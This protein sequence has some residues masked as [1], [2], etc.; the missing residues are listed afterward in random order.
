MSADGTGSAQRY[1]SWQQVLGVGL[2][3]ACSLLSSHLSAQT[4]LSTIRGVVTDTSGGVLPG[5]DIV[6]IDVSTNLSRSTVSDAA[7]NFEISHL[8]P[9]TYRLEAHFPGFKGFIADN[10]ILESSQARRIDI[11]LAV[12]EL[13]SEV[14]VNP[15]A[16]VIETEDARLSAVLRNEQYQDTPFVSRSRF[17]P[18]MLLTLPGVQPPKAGHNLSLA[19]MT[20]QITQGMDGVVN[21]G[22]VNQIQNMDDV[23]ETK[24]VT[25]N[26]TA[27]VARAGSFNLVSKR[28]SNEFHGQVYYYNVDSSLNSRPFFATTKPTLD[29]HTY[30]ASASGP[31]KTGRTFFYT[32][33]NGIRDPSKNSIQSTVPTVVMRNG[34]F[35]ELLDE[36]N[37]IVIRDPLADTPFPGNVI[38]AARLNSVAREVQ[39]MI[40]PA[41]NL[42][43]FTANLDWQ[44]PYAA[45]Y[46]RVDYLTARIDHKV[47][48]NNELY[49]RLSQRFTPYVLSGSYPAL[50]W[51]RRRYAFQMAIND[52]HVF[53]PSLIHSFRFGWYRNR[54]TDGEAID[55]FTPLRGDRVVTDLGIQGVNRRGLSGA[56]FP[57][58]NITGHGAIS[59]NPSGTSTEDDIS[60]SDNVT[61]SMGRHVV[62][63][64]ADLR[65][66][67][68]A[69]ETVPGLNYGSFSFDGTWSG[70]PYA[71][72]LLGLP[73]TSERLD[74]LGL[75]KRSGYE[76][77]AYVMDSF[78]VS[79]RLTLDYGL[80]WDYF[81][82]G[83]YEDGLQFNWN[84]VTGD[85]IVPSAAMDSI[86]PLYPLDQITVVAGD[87]VPS[88]DK[89]NFAP[90]L[91]AAYR[92]NDLTVIRGGYGIFN[93]FQG[94]YPFAEGGGPFEIQESFINQIENG[95]PL[96]E[97][98]NPFP[99]GTGRIP[100]QSI[101]GY[102]M[103]VKDGYI[104]QFN[105][106]V[107][108]QVGDVGVRIS[109]I[110]TRARG[111]NYN[112]Q[113][114]KPEPSLEPFSQ[115][116]RPYTQFVNTSYRQRDGAVNYDAMTLQASRKVGRIAFNT[117]WTWA[118]NVANYLNL[119][120]PYDHLKWNRVSEMPRHRVVLSA[121]L[122]LPRVSAAGRPTILK[123][124]LDDWR[125]AWHATMQTG[126]FF[127]PIF[128]G[129][130][131]SNTGTF[132]GLPNRIGDGNLPS[133]QRRVDRWFDPSA[134][135]LPQQGQ[136]GNAGVNILKG[137]SLHVHNMSLTKS[138]GL[139]GGSQRMELSCAIGNLF[140]RA[141]FTDPRNNISVPDA[142]R[143]TGTL[144]VNNFENADARR[145][146]LRLRVLW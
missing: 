108:R 119:E 8:N 84:P 25:V 56:G 6:V 32:S 31:I 136:F 82:P 129:R 22:A 1:A 12:G 78:K 85:V 120:N 88:P 61:W 35:S 87:V 64:G 58:L 36:A 50:S 39:E 141:N 111:L 30:G 103:D 46:Y 41:P 10:L 142:G 112:L 96:F 66:L 60:F 13:T 106:T 21:D 57:I 126:T 40:L 69:S 95:Q 138:F 3:L 137:P 114:N 116:R 2:L 54:I 72:F 80:R 83:T 7:G 67:Y 71:D 117:H 79:S 33:Y 45:D 115:S 90:R 113:I 92:I 145:I 81:N 26:N 24:I 48:T 37:P 99:S 59:V 23:E 89:T 53:S 19:G 107:E 121:A 49:G 5:T 127:S 105:V 140:N 98:P 104:Q 94:R 14:I 18:M 43:G 47:S 15:S 124:I 65:K 75:R 128:S 130:D 63:F 97:L 27:D 132:S 55:G 91:G 146:E 38:P 110:G 70:Y 133:D 9:G 52:T 44:H 118:A 17:T 77:G 28:G 68:T 101:S 4:T 123:A 42:P 16:A 73:I 93:E 125:L 86:S 20:G 29:M 134:F 144:G 76:F 34:D 143:I 131:V 122:A 102:P 109:Y 139:P 135:V 74:P 100:A 62:K 11:Q 51:T